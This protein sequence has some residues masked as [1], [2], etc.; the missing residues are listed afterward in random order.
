[1]L[2]IALVIT[3][4]F[5]VVEPDEFILIFPLILVQVGVVPFVNN[6]CDVEPPANFDTVIFAFVSTSLLIIDDDDITPELSECKTPDEYDVS[7][8]SPSFILTPSINIPLFK[9]YSLI[10][11]TFISC[12]KVVDKSNVFEPVKVLLPPMI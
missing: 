2:I 8:I 3:L 6:N 9:V 1:M 7:I 11:S 12:L 5:I 10:V 4:L